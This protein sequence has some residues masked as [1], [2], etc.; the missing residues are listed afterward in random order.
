ML[1][2][3]LSDL[4]TRIKQ[5]ASFRQF[6]NSLPF[7]LNAEVL[8]HT[9]KTNT[10][11]IVYK[12]TL[13]QPTTVM[14]EVTFSASLD[15]RMFPRLD[16]S[17]LFFSNLWDYPNLKTLLPDG[18]GETKG[19]VLSRGFVL[20]PERIDSTF[21]RDF[22]TCFLKVAWKT[23]DGTTRTEYVQVTASPTPELMAYIEKHRKP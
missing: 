1:L 6:D 16:T 14:K 2:Q 7:R 4:E 5:P 12:I 23:P 10:E 11:R 9:D 19:L 22:R 20:D 15:P 21:V 3:D 13:D 18:S 8:Y 17:G